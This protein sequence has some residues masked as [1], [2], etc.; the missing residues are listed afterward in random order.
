MRFRSVLYGSLGVVLAHL[1]VFSGWSSPSAYSSDDALS[2]GVYVSMLSPWD[3]VLTGRERYKIYHVDVKAGEVW[4]FDARSPHFSPFLIVR[5]ARGQRDAGGV[6]GMH[7]AELVYEARR[8]ERLALLVSTSIRGEMGLFA[9]NVHASQNA[10]VVEADRPFIRSE[11]VENSRVEGTIDG[12]TDRTPTGIGVDRYEYMGVAGER[13][14]IRVS[15]PRFVPLVMVHGPGVA[16]HSADPV[17]RER[18]AVIEVELPQSGRYVIRVLSGPNVLDASY[19]LRL[20]N[21]STRTSTPRLVVGAHVEG[22]LAQATPRLSNDARASRYRL[23]LEKG[24]GVQLLLNAS[25]FEGKVRVSAPAPT[26]LDEVDTAEQEIQDRQ[27]YESRRGVLRFHAPSTGDYEVV[28]SAPRVDQWGDYI[29][30]VLRMEDAADGGLKDAGNNASTRTLLRAGRPRLGQLKLGAPQMKDLSYY[31]V[32]RLPVN[33][34]ERWTVEMSSLSFDTHLELRGPQGFALSN[35]DRDALSTDS[36]L[37]FDAPFSGDLT[38]YATSH[39]PRALG[40]FS[41]H[42]YKGDPAPRDAEEPQGRLIALLV[43]ISEYG[44]E[45]WESLP[46]CAAD[47]VRL[48]GALESTGML[49]PESMIL[50]DAH[51]TRD[52]LVKALERAAEV[53][54]P[55]DVFLFFFSGHGGQL[56]SDDPMERDG[57]DETLVLHDAQIRD[58]ELGDLLLNVDSRL[59]LVVLDACY[60]GGFRD[61]LRRRKNQIGIFSSEEDVSSL[62]AEQFEAGGY[63][64]NILLYG[65]A[66]GADRG[67]SDGVV[68]VDELLQYLRMAWNEFGQV[69]AVDS[70]DRFAHQE[71]VIE[72]GYT[73]PQEVIL[74]RPATQR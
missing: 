45:K 62:V 13:I 52:E 34:G 66:G 49:A 72:R 30:S 28:V 36:L 11:L 23:R 32:Y 20:R 27:I 63:L 58:D 69:L 4:T 44:P 10:H 24:Q 12:S 3:R 9:L 74:K 22:T 42:A 26:L 55:N 47:A 33:A 29:L 57:L 35:D 68:T 41:V 40:P 15:S 16:L 5:G 73:S 61:T 48:G 64:S 50:V 7:R 19:T 38:I 43:G 25:D 14:V 71:L 21:R 67:P 70:N 60:S 2:Q 37:T 1:L 6:L 59:S 51:A 8:D 17:G 39:L 46:Y 65:L 56:P 31:Q 18:A 53:V 54:Q